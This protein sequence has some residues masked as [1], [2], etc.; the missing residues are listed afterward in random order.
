MALETVDPID[1]SHPT[2]MG[3]TPELR[4]LHGVNAFYKSQNL[5]QQPVLEH[6]STGMPAQRTTSAA[7]QGEVKYFNWKQYFCVFKFYEIQ[8]SSVQHLL[9]VLQLFLLRLFHF[10]LF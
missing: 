9:F 5:L 7:A 4:E 2:L 1:W 3:S 6:A 8:T 10:Y